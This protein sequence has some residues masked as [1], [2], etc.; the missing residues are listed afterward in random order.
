[1]VG[2]AVVGRGRGEGH[3]AL[4]IDPAGARHKVATH[5]HLFGNAVKPPDAKGAVDAAAPAAWQALL[6]AAP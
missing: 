2:T 5:A 4:W 3:R 1:M 6:R